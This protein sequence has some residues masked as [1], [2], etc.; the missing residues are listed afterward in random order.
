MLCAYFVVTNQCTLWNMYKKSIGYPGFQIAG[1]VL[2]WY[3]DHI[4]EVIIPLLQCL[5]RYNISKDI[6]KMIVQRVLTDNCHE[7]KPKKKWLG[8][9]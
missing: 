6:R 8:I 2:K 3:P 9:F 1:Y 7:Y 5:H 4:I